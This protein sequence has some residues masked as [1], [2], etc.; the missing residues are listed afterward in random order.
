MEPRP[1][2][3]VKKILL[4]DDSAVNREVGAAHLEK[5][6]FAVVTAADGARA[7]ELTTKQHFDLVLLDI[8]MP[9]LSGLEVLTA[10]RRDHPA[11]DLP[12]IM[13][14][15]KDGSQDMVQAFDLGA[16]D[17][18]TKPIDWAVVQA[19]ILAHL[20]T[21]KSEGLAVETHAVGDLGPGSL[22][23][24]RYR[25]EELLGHGRHGTVYRARQLELDR[26][27]A[28]KVLR[29]PA[30]DDPELARRLEREGISA[31]RVQ[32]PNA[33][34]VYDFAVTPQGTPFLVMELLEGESLDAELR[35][36]P[37]SPERCTEILH[38]V[39]AALEEAHRHGVIHRDIK[40]H[41][42]FLHHPRPGV[43][44]VKVVDFGIATF[45]D[46]FS[47]DQRLTAAGNRPG[48]PA[49]M[50]PER[51]SDEPYD[52]RVD[53][54]SLGITLY[55]LLTGEL[56]YNVEDGNLLRIIRMHLAGDP[57]PLDRRRSDLT[58]EIDRT[59]RRAMSKDPDERPGLRQLAE[60]FSDAVAATADRG[61]SGR[62]DDMASSGTPPVL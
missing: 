32:H 10:L 45:V 22:L 49:Y 17:Y 7:L 31:C 13:A 15:A 8:V 59:V 23:A 40:P 43:E 18:V 48:T 30:P 54:Y 26:P 25:L 46:G 33:V 1:E 37:L 55:E 53:V 14:T 3:S 62:V 16:T 2:P 56:P 20:R 52:G 50:A 39:C 58:P 4:V 5:R 28:V 27:V 29:T 12:I 36:G 41:N 44:T 19:R 61:G 21:R 6:G 57:V 11:G 24:D 34:A 35:R 60:S 42:I 47:A 9:G 51:F 38:P